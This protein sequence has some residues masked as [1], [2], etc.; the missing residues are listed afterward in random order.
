MQ[1]IIGSSHKACLPEFLNIVRLPVALLLLSLETGQV[2][3][4]PTAGRQCP[5]CQGMA[6]CTLATSTFKR[7]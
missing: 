2:L 3:A 1:C 4:K 7:R 6:V 5:L